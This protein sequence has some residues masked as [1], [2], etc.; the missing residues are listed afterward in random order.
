MFFNIYIYIYTQIGGRS[1][2]E[3][4]KKDKLNEKINAL[5]GEKYHAFRVFVFGKG[6]ST[7]T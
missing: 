3:A 7:T 4:P 6:G 2:E 5:C 1:L